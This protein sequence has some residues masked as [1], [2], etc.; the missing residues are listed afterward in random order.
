M[1][2]QTNINRIAETVVIMVNA[3]ITLV[4]HQHNHAAQQQA[5]TGEGQP[6]AGT[7]RFDS[8]ANVLAP[9]LLAP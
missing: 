7:A 4:D 3:P 5:D 8:L 1:M 9:R 6:S 2:V